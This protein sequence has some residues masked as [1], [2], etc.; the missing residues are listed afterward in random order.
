MIHGFYLLRRKE[1]LRSN[2][3]FNPEDRKEK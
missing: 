2:L 3:I 1:P